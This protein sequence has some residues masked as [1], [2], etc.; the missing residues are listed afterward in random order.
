VQAVARALAADDGSLAERLAAGSRVTLD[1]DDGPVEVG[2]DDV[3]LTREVLAGWGVASDGG[4]TVALE[5]ELTPALRA[6]G[7][8]RELVRV[9]QD[10]RRAAGLEVQDRIVV[11][12]VATG[13]LAEARDMHSG[14]IAG[15]TLATEVRTDAP[16]DAAH[17]TH[18][19]IDGMPVAVGVR[20]A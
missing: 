8:A 6:E 11:Y 10:A 7:L 9:V 1:L 2:H 15:E 19:D 20:L 4:V 16:D 5:L 18:V 13:E 12:L 14:F 17:T 3:V